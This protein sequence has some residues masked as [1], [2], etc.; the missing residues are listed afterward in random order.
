MV[1][2]S[3]KPPRSPA[4]AAR[5][6]APLDHALDAR[7]FQALGDPT[8]LELL[9]CLA[10]CGRP[11][12]VSELACCCAVDLSVVSRHLAR[13]ERDGLLARVRSGRTVSYAVRYDDVAARLRAM[14]DALDGCCPGEEGCC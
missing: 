11:C 9:A 12:T 3:T 13:L 4:A 6:K 10:K 7:W 8:R 5:R 2:A 1:Q 14:A